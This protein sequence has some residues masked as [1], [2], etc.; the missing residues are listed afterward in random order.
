MQKKYE[1]TDKIK[2]NVKK[3]YERTGPGNA[4]IEFKNI[5]EM[6][7]DIMLKNEKK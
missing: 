3:D 6:V 4:K 7:D 1:Q 2:E 5:K